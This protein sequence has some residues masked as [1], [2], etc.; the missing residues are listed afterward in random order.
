M[1][2][3]LAFLAGAAIAGFLA[4]LMTYTTVNA[5]WKNDCERIG[6]HLESSSEQ[7]VYKCE[8]VKR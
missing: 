1:D 5:G 6:H 7:K 8:L 4:G 3:L 2:T